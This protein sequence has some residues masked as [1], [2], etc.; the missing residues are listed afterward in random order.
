MTSFLRWLKWIVRG[1]VFLA[2]FF[3][4]VN[5]RQDTTVHLMFGHAWSGPLMLILLVA[6][7]IGVA[8]GVIGML[9]AWWRRGRA[10]PA[11]PAAA[12]TRP[13]DDAPATTPPP[14]GI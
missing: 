5:N 3:F 1:A 14:H 13:P 7:L 10:Q 9:P 11:A 12:P 2:L 6:F 8:V 4:A